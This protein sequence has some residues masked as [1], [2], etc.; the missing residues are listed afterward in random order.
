MRTRSGP[1]AGPLAA[2]LSTGMPEAIV[3]ASTL[4]NSCPAGLGLPAPIAPLRVLTSDG[5]FDSARRVSRAG[6]RWWSSRPRRAGAFDSFAGGSRGRGSGDMT[7]LCQPNDVNTGGCSIWWLLWRRS[8][9]PKG[10]G[11]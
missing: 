7:D 4:M 8:G 1:G 3:F 5:E 9:R 11:W 10:R 6:R 2:E